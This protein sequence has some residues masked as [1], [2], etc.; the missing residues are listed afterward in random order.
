MLKDLV[1]LTKPRIIRLNLIAAFGGY[2]VASKWV[3]ILSWP[4]LWM[5]IGSALTMASACVFNNYLDRELDMKMA[6]TRDGAVCR[7]TG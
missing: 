3:N 7:K 2:W 5:L 6:R 4:L 1:A